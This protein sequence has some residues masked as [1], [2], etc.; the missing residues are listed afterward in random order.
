M[1]DT[2]LLDVAGTADVLAASTAG[3][4]RLYSMRTRSWSDPLPTPAGERAVDI[5]ERKGTWIA[6]SEANRLVLVGA[7]PSILIGG[8]AADA[9]SA[10][11]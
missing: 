3:G 4:V 6:R 9:A 7:R 10:A 8:G 11:E 2:R 1:A 5:A